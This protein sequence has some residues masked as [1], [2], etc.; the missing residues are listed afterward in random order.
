MC[1]ITCNEDAD[2]MSFADDFKKVDFIDDCEN[3]CLGH[4]S[5]AKYLGCF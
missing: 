4:S 1:P 2:F 5:L 3:R